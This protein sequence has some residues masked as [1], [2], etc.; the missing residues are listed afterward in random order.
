MEVEEGGSKFR[1][2]VILSFQP[3]LQN[4]LWIFIAVKS[5][6]ISELKTYQVDKSKE[7]WVC[8]WS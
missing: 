6:R 4:I 8:L 1:K 5:N 2:M 3:S 7:F